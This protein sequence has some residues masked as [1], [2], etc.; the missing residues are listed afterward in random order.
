MDRQT[1]AGQSDPYV[2]LCFASNTKTK[3]ICQNEKDGH[4]RGFLYSREDSPGEFLKNKMFANKISFTVFSSLQT[5]AFH[6]KYYCTA[7]LD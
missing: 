7:K 5:C 3:Y 1:N 2:P 6:H 4:I